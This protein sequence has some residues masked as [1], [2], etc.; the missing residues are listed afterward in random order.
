MAYR[1]K[2]I[3]LVFKKTVKDIPWYIWVIAFFI[4]ALFS[5]SFFLTQGIFPV[6]GAFVSGVGVIILVVILWSI[7]N[8]IEW[9]GKLV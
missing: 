2:A 4:I 1:L 9:Y 3:K 6:I 7:F 8:I 5:A